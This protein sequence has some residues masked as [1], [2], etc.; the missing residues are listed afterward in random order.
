MP[1]Q[2]HHDDQRQD[3][4]QHSPERQGIAVVQRLAGGDGRASPCRAVL[5]FVRELDGVA[6]A[7]RG[8]DVVKQVVGV[9]RVEGEA[10]S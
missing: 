3:R 6:E 2:Q 9:M 10:G 5:Q 1:R 4:A 8:L 7:L